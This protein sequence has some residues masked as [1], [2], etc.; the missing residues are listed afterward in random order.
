MPSRGSCSRRRGP[1]KRATGARLVAWG[2]PPLEKLPQTIPHKECQRSFRDPRADNTVQLQVRKIR[3]DGLPGGCSPCLQNHTECRTTDR[4]TG[5]ATSRGYVEGLE[6][7][8]R[9][10]QTRIQELEQRLMQN[11]LDVKP[12]NGFKSSAAPTYDNNPPPSATQATAW[13]SSASHYTSQAGD[14]LRTQPESGLFHAPST[15]RTAS[16]SDNY[17]GVFFGN[18]NLS[19]KGTALSILGMEID[20]ADFDSPDMDE[21]DPSV[22]YPHLYN[23]SYEAFLRTTLN[24]NPRIEKVDLPNRTDGLTYAEWYFRALNAYFPIL[25]KPTFMK[26]VSSHLQLLLS[27]GD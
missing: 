19:L 8:N 10:M 2:Q 13:S 17:L 3:C 1:A 7:Q 20:I 4:I 9:E 6:Q 11:G 18:P 14:A 24:V 12:S 27:R 15:L 16:T 21:P 22:F 5:R 26:T 23:K 25:H